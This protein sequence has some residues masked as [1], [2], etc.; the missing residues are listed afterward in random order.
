MVIGLRLN[1][2]PLLLFGVFLLHINIP[3]K[4]VYF[5]RIELSIQWIIT[6]SFLNFI[7]MELSIFQLYLNFR[8]PMKDKVVKDF[9]K[10]LFIR[11]I[12]L[13]ATSD[14]NFTIQY[15]FYLSYRWSRSNRKNDTKNCII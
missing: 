1:F 2:C 5:L 10:K 6:V 13:I 4:W 14:Q 11:I 8:Y 7:M 3:L 12:Q 15:F 9:G